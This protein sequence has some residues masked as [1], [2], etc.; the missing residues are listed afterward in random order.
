MKKFVKVMGIVLISFLAIMCI[1]PFAFKGKVK[2]MVISEGNK[3]LNAEFGFDD[4]NISL[5]REF[6]KASIGIEGFWLRGV[7]A[8]EN[9][10]LIAV[11]ELRVSVDIMSLFGDKGFNISK[12]LLDNTKLNA[13]ILESGKVNWDIIKSDSLATIQEEDSTSTSNFRIVLDELSVEDL[14][15]TFTDH[16]SKTYASVMGLNAI[17]S[18]DMSAENTMFDLKSSIHSLTLEVGDIPY[19]SQARIDAD[20]NI[21]A[22]LKN[23][24]FTL[25]ENTIALNAIQATFDGWVNMPENSPMSMDIRLNSSE[26]NFKEILSLIPAIYAKDFESLKADGNVTLSAYAKGELSGDTLLPKFDIHLN[27]T[28]GSFRYPE[29]PAG[30]D[31]IQINASVSNPGGTADLTSINVENLRFN[32]LGNEFK[33]KAG[34]LTP[35]SDP[36]FVLSANGTIDLGQIKNIYP[37]EDITLNGLFNA[38]MDFSG[39]LS[40]ID[41][42]EYDRFKA[43]GSIK[44]KDMILRMKEIPDVSILKSTFTFT[45]KSLRLSETTVNIGNNDITAD[46]LFENYLA[47]FLK[48]KTLKGQL[49]VQ[50]KYFNLNDFMTTESDTNVATTDTTTTIS[51]ATGT[52]VIPKN[53]DFNMNVNM[54]EILFDK[55][56]IDNLNGKLIVNNGTADMKNLSMNVMGGKVVMNGAYSTEK[57]EKQPKLNA[58][59][60]MSDISFAQAFKEL[61]MIQKM[62]PIFENLKGDF[63]GKMNIETQ[64]D[65]V[66]SPILQ[67]L[68]GNGSLSTSDLNLSNVEILNKIADA[69]KYDALRDINV[70]NMKVDFIIDK[71]R[72]NTK[73]FD[74]N[75]GKINL[76]LAGSTGLDQTI[77]YTGKLKLP[78]STG[79]L[80]SLTT[81]DLKINGTFTN[82]QISIDTKSMVKQATNVMAEKAVN[83]IGEKLGVDLSDAEKQKEALV[84]AATAAAERLLSEAQKQSDNLV[85]KAGN[86]VLKKLA[87]QKAG[88]AIVSEAKK[89][90][91]K[92]IKEATEKG[93]ALIEKAK[94][95]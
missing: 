89:Q 70:K 86:N 22:D 78:Q 62:A 77:D 2:E 10:T 45:P 5:L 57:S 83:A 15:I 88:D 30:V 61:D 11:N 35:I 18:G 24:K 81:I 43:N 82:P 68:T 25:K 94:N 64:L 59:F 56:T 16:Q 55:I 75:M 80:A 8:F 72:L 34:I 21:D 58:S 19:L 60:N 13:I 29:L 95:E 6:P 65:S 33:A 3:M 50:S 17:C 37:L 26:I 52:I 36:E 46:C 32:M 87:A 49:N 23:G 92:L 93:D 31:N 1:L 39:H 63:S 47:Y 74:I 79:S 9:D 71:G 27:V 41:K 69:T 85:S 66:M 48:N 12:I 44:L 91:E 4:V 54:Q 14:N 40:Y 84:S 28:D 76:N 90:G 53:I 51:E 7:N 67:T 42:E 20:L 38:N 73:P